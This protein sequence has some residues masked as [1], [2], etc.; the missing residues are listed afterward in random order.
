[1]TRIKKKDPLENTMSNDSVEAKPRFLVDILGQGTMISF[2]EHELVR[3][4]LE[5]VIEFGLHSI[6][7]GRVPARVQFYGHEAQEGYLRYSMGKGFIDSLTD[8]SNRVYD[9]SNKN[10]MNEIIELHAYRDNILGKKFTQLIEG[11]YIKPLGIEEKIYTARKLIL[12]FD[13]K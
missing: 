9:T 6:L 1:M 8:F 7:I 11:R 12:D 4:E 13:N 2:P 5:P 10:D 3:V